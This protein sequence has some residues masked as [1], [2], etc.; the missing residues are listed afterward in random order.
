MSS[1]GKRIRLAFGG[2]RPDIVETVR[3]SEV[4]SY[5]DR[6]RD[7]GEASRDYSSLIRSYR[8]F[9][10][11]L[12]E[13]KIELDFLRENGEKRFTK[14]AGEILDGIGSIDES[15]LSSFGQFYDDTTQAIQSIM[16]VPGVI[17]RRTLRYEN[18]RETID[19][20]NSLL[21]S[22]RNMKKVSSEVL[23]ENSVLKHH[24]SALREYRALQEALRKKEAL[25]K[26]I[27]SLEKEMEEKSGRLDEATANLQAAQSEIDN[28][29]IVEAERR[30]ASVERRLRQINTDLKFNLRRGRRPISK[31]LHSEDR[32][33]FRFY[34]R[35]TKHPLDNINERFWQMIAIL[36]RQNVNLGEKERKEIDDFVSFCRDRLQEMIRE[37]EDAEA[38]KGR[39]EERF[40]EI[41]S[42]SKEL[43]G[44]LELR[45]E[46][47]QNDLA[48]ASTR[49]EEMEREKNTLE[50]DVEK[51]VRMLEKMLS[52]I[53]SNKV[54]IE[55]G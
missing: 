6:L 10:G 35:F 42:R 38:E 26:G 48:S 49:L 18:G 46:T 16:K 11:E 12:D 22:F 39:S 31:I 28:E 32:R 25:Q 23:S 14:I 4:E 37:Y 8:E 21:K 27:E 34:K 20:L 17:Q 41:S 55:F 30:V 45:K 1:L 51:T 52:K 50:V 2:K 33:L 40:N 5:I 24:R 19:A 47:A 36:E 54:R 53:G 9:M 29:A 3:F 43:L 13:V 44:D 7:T 15:D